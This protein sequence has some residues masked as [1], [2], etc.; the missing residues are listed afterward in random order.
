[1]T[2]LM[3]EL[4]KTAYAIFDKLFSVYFRKFSKTAYE[5]SL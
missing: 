4:M 2:Y 1:M 3:G 5:N